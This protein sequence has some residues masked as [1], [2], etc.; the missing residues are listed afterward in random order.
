MIVGA[1]TSFT[2]P[3]PLLHEPPAMMK[4]FTRVSWPALLIV[5]TGPWERPSRMAIFSPKLRCARLVSV[6][7]NPAYIATLGL[8][9]TSWVYVPLATQNWSPG[10]AAAIAFVMVCFAS[11]ELVPEEA[12]WRVV[13][14]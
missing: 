4:P 11:V 2:L 14:T 12:S 1:E 7:L 8:S 9:F 10:T 6:P 5:T 3:E 13:L